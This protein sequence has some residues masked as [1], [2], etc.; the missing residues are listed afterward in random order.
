MFD[1]ISLFVTFAVLL[2]CVIGVLFYLGSNSNY[3]MNTK[4]NL[5]ISAGVL[6]V[7]YILM[8]GGGYIHLT[9]G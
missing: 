1:L 9:K 4:K 8:I 3:D 6:L 7:F 5:N 2:F